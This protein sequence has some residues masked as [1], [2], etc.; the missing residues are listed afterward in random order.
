M[1]LLN[2]KRLAYGQRAEG[3]KAGRAEGCVGL[4]RDELEVGEAGEAGEA[5]GEQTACPPDRLT[6][7]PPDFEAEI[8]KIV[9]QFLAERRARRGK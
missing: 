3:R 6:A 9:E 7:S 4:E 2:V 8:R 1:H 5:G